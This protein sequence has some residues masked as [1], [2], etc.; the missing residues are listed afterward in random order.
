MQVEEQKRHETEKKA[1]QLTVE[2]LQF[3]RDQYCSEIADI[4][5]EAKCQSIEAQRAMESK[6]KELDTAL[7]S[8]LRMQNQLENVRKDK[9]TAIQ[10]VMAKLKKEQ[11]HVSQVHTTLKQREA[12]NSYLIEKTKDLEKVEQ[13][14]V[15][16]QCS[17]HPQRNQDSLETQFQS[18]KKDSEALQKELQTAQNQLKELSGLKN[19]LKD[20]NSQREIM[21]NK[22]HALEKEKEE[23]KKWNEQLETTSQSVQDELK[24]RCEEIKRLQQRIESLEK[25]LVNSQEAKYLRTTIYVLEIL[26][27]TVLPTASVI[28][29]VSHCNG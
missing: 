1:L 15:T 2:Q 27:I 23:L 17:D 5:H 6:S 4:K 21:H 3:E 7:N 29:D 12:E 8:V 9:E 24:E 11:E 10:E 18:I 19:Q 26:M 16:I 28:I 13:V 20:I 25:E 22:V 14:K